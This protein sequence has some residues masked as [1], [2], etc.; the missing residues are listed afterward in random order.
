MQYLQSPVLTSGV[1]YSDFKKSNEFYKKIL[2]KFA[3][4]QITGRWRYQE[5]K[6]CDTCNRY[7]H[8]IKKKIKVDGKYKCYCCAYNWRDYTLL[9]TY[10][11]T[12]N[13][14]KD[15]YKRDIAFH[16]DI[17]ENN[18]Y[19]RE[20]ITQPER[21]LTRARRDSFM[22]EVSW[23]RGP[24]QVNIFGEHVSKRLIDNLHFEK[25]FLYRYRNELRTKTSRM[26]WGVFALNKNENEFYL[27]TELIIAIIYQTMYWIPTINY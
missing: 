20:T 14:Y 15:D 22:G 27:P 21:A 11:N 4:R 26:F 8:G 9:N 23:T 24:P 3:S 7:I 12:V 19:N 6:Y 2:D 16:L 17:L 25:R 1:V 13:D 18:I 5:S 10:Y